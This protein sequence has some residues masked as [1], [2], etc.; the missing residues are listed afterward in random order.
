[1]TQTHLTLR[2]G[3]QGRVSKGGN[4]HLASCPPFETLA[5]LAPQGEV[6]GLES[7]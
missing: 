6:M 5:A 1:M 3:L 4:T 7:A 2:S